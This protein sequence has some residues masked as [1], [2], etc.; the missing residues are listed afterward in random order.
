MIGK[1]LF[2]TSPYGSMHEL[3]FFTVISRQFDII[4]VVPLH[5]GSIYVFG[6]RGKKSLKLTKLF[7]PRTVFF[8]H[9]LMLLVL[10]LAI[11][12]PYMCLEGRSSR[13]WLNYFILAGRWR[14]RKKF[15]KLIKLFYPSQQATGGGMVQVLEVDWII[16]V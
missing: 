14:E 4:G 16:L 3:L 6:R 2:L 7:Y 9:D 13:S 1:Y 12:N 15:S 11:R 10:S 8:F 5:T